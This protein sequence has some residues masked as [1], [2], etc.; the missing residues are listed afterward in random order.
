MKTREQAEAMA[1]EL[2]P[3]NSIPN[4]TTVYQSDIE[5]EQQRKAFLKC[6][7]EMT[8]HKDITKTCG[9]CV[10]P[11]NNQ[12][13]SEHPEEK[14]NKFVQKELICEMMR[15]DEE[16]GVYVRSITNCPTCGAECT[17]EGEGETH[18]YLPK[19]NEVR[20]AAEMSLET[21]KILLNEL[22]KDDVVL[23]HE[24]KSRKKQLEKALK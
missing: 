16:S 6:F 9:Y 12:P 21:M 20:E 2:F 10:K 18:Y 5:N 7:D 4:S 22:S 17:V 8:K 11:N 15:K 3:D 1:M 24:V 19:D 14:V 23:I 13:I